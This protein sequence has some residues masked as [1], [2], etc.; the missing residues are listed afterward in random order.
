M[1]IQPDGVESI[2]SIYFCPKCHLFSVRGVHKKAKFARHIKACDG[3]FHSDLLL[4]KVAQPYCPAI[5]A[6]PVV[7]YCMAY[8]RTWKPYHGFITYDFETVEDIVDSYITASTQLNSTLSPISVASCSHFQSG[9]Q[10]T[11][12]FDACDPEFIPKWIMSLFHHAD[13]MLHEKH[14]FLSQML[15]N[16]RASDDTVKSLHKLDTH[17]TC[18]N[19]YGYNSSRFDSNLFKE[20]FNYS[21]GK[22]SWHVDSPIGT[23]SILKQFI[24]TSSSFNARLRFLDAQAFVAGGILKEF[25][26]DFGNAGDDKGIFPYEAINTTNYNE[27]LSKQEPFEHS[28]FFSTLRTRSTSRIIVTLLLDGITCCTITIRMSRS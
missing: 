17:T 4:D 19:V 24:L 11:D 7:E 8:N 27:I 9:H 13:E 2:T 1:F 14:E 20:Y 16:K 3:K 18:N 23:G 28:D 21:F 5:L 12:H 6:N 26:K 10:T 22:V 15:Y 25:A